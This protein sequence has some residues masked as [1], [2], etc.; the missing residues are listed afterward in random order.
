MTD[1]G[2]GMTD[3]GHVLSLTRFPVKSLQGE[4]LD[5]LSVDTRGVVGDRRWCVRT[6]DG[7]IAS[8]KATRR[9]RKVGGL[10]DLRAA[11]PEGGGSPVV[12][13]PDG[14]GHEV[15]TPAAN[16]ALEAVSGR[17]VTFV[18]E[19]RDSHFDEGPLHLLTTA[20]L[21]R[22]ADE[23]GA[24]VDPR[25]FR[26]NV[27]LDTPGLNGLPEAAWEGRRLAVGGDVVLEVAYPMPRCVMVTMPT[28]DLGAD[29]RVLKAVHAVAGGD[30]G[31][32]ARV[33]TPG[34]IGVGDAV[35]LLG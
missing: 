34:R 4:Q 13:F 5:A 30:L 31:V 24:A 16:R 22:L 27:L 26:A 29:P 23:L 20:S 17:A 9:F 28:A 32:M 21:R 6:E 33:V 2:S 14:T 12:T 7:F 1:V 18:P 15:G 3:V 35:R 10:L 19:S 8:G 25:R 11:L